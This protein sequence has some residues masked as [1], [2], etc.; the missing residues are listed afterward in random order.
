MRGDPNLAEAPPDYELVTNLMA[1]VNRLQQYLL[2]RIEELGYSESEVARR[3]GTDRQRLHRLL[4]GNPTRVP[5]T[6][7]LDDLARVLEVPR[8]V[9][10]R[11]AA[12]SWGYTIT[13]GDTDDETSTLV[14]SLDELPE[15]RRRD[16]MRLADL[17]LS[18]SKQAEEG[19]RRPPRDKLS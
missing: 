6:E 3:A 4:H 1:G 13:G 15:H 19:R 2:D 12:E 10:R 17:Y 18:E 14:A 11:L 5:D 8:R 9:L 7:F 16:L